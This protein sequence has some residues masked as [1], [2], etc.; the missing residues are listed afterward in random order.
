MSAKG[1]PTKRTHTYGSW[2]WNNDLLLSKIGVADPKTGCREWLGSRG[3]QT[4]L[5]GATRNGQPQMTQARR[6]YMFGQHP[7]LPNLEETACRMRCFNNFCMEKNHMILATNR[8]LGE[9]V[10][11]EEK[12]DR[13]FTETRISIERWNDLTEEEQEQIKELARQYNA[14][15]QFDMEFQFYKVTWTSY[16]WF[17]VKLKNPGVTDHLRVYQRK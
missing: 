16:N 4:G 17:T 8:R 9:P 12:M 13:G 1:R 11:Q 3:K 15:V 6:L 7:E 14:Q 2:T 10:P 5:F